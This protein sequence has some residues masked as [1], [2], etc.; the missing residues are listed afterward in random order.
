MIGG[1][2]LLHRKVKVIHWQDNP[3]GT[4]TGTIEV[5]W[6]KDRE[7][8]QPI[9]KP[10]FYT[11]KVKQHPIENPDDSYRDALEIIAQGRAIDEIE[12]E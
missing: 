11:G 4:R 7:L 2:Q 1:R 12:A 8:T 9:D 3:D 5:Q 6:F 10:T